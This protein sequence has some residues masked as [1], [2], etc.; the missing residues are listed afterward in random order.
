MKFCKLRENLV[1]NCPK[2]DVIGL[3]LYDSQYSSCLGSA[4]HKNVCLR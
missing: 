1:G 4:G 3:E 2:Y